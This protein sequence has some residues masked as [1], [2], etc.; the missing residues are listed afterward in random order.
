VGLSNKKPLKNVDIRLSRAKKISKVIGS[1]KYIRILSR[2]LNLDNLELKEIVG[3]YK[4]TGNEAR[5]K[6]R[7]IDKE[8]KEAQILHTAILDNCLFDIIVD[9]LESESVDSRKY[10]FGIF[11]DTFDYPVPDRPILVD[12]TSSSL[13]EKIQ[14][15]I[16]DNLNKDYDI[17]VRPIKLLDDDIS[18][19]KRLIDVITSIISRAFRDKNN[20][21]PLEEIKLLLQDK[22]HESNIT[23]ETISF[24]KHMISKVQKKLK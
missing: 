23:K 24:Y 15:D 12:S 22:Y 19:R 3:S 21:S 14:E 4:K 2:Y 20:G 16:Q 5:K 18:K 1:Q 11:I 17:S 9:Y 10:N 8:R 6:C 13:E 7:K